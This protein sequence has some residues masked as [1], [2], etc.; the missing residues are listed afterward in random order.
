LIDIGSFI[1]SRELIGDTYLKDGITPDGVWVEELFKKAK[2]PLY[3][4][5]TFSIYNY[6][7]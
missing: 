6:L 3:I 4:N 2:N 1:V 5:K 7:R